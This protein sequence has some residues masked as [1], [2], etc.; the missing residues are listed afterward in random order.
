MEL[1]ATPTPAKHDAQLVDVLNSLGQLHPGDMALENI[2]DDVADEAQSKKTS[3]QEPAVATENAEIL[4]RMAEMEANLAEMK[5]SAAI[6]ALVAQTSLT[7]ED[8]KELL[9]ELSAG[10]KPEEVILKAVKKHNE[11][12]LQA[13]DGEAGAGVGGTAGSML[14]FRA[15]NNGFVSATADTPKSIPNFAE[16][17]IDQ[18]F[19]EFQGK[20]ADEIADHFFGV[21][22]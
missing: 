2:G 16:H 5:A 15:I 6:G 9:A 4:K 22:Y 14:P 17:G 10:A 20:T 11:R 18:K 3:A 12:R 1:S 19:K 21:D 7:E 8:S 13:S